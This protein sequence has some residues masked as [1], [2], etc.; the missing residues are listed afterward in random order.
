M[1][2][3]EEL[4][5]GYVDG[6]L[7]QDERQIVERHL[8]SCERCRHELA[9]ARAA[10]GA[11]AEVPQVEAP[12]GVASRAL[13]EA[14]QAAGQGSPRWYRFAPIAAAAAVLLVLAIA[15]PRLGNQQGAGTG[16]APEAA[17]NVSGAAAPAKGAGADVP[18]EV[19]AGADY[20]AEAIKA[21]AASAAGTTSHAP[22]VPE[23]PTDL[24]P[25]ASVR[26][27]DARACLLPT[28]RVLPDAQL[29]RLIAATFEGTPVYIAVFE[30]GPGGTQP[31]TK[32]TVW[33]VSRDNCSILSFADQHMHPS[34]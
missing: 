5:A 27:Q 3:P 12:A 23:N 2:H 33:V 30:E 10:V 19:Q 18:L 16:A 1:A 34:P 22:S 14:S 9:L 24:V 31:P 8:A 7:D 4:L 32:V 29:V 15:I 21:L 26:A 11:L 25:A 20:D 28:V 17:G 6:S 13:R